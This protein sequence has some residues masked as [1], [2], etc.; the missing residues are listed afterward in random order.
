MAAIETERMALV[1]GEW[2]PGSAGS[3]EIRSPWDGSVVGAATAC[4][5]D[6][7]ALAV[8]AAEK[9]QREWA[10][11]SLL[12]RVDLFY[13]AMELAE[14]R[15]EAIAGLITAEM[16]K[17]IRESR[18][19][20]DEFGVPHFRRAAE[21]ALRYRGL[22]FPSTQERSNAKKMVMNRRPLG[23]VGVISPYNFPVDIALITIT[24]SLI[25]GNAV[26]WKPSELTPLSSGLAAEVFVEAGFPE[27]LVNF[28][29]GG[30]DVGEAIV[31]S[32]KVGAVSFTGSTP[33]GEAITRG[34]GLKRLLLELGGNGPIIVLADADLDR[35]VE[36]TIVGCFYM[37]GQCCTAAE[38]ILVDASVEE[39]YVAKLVARTER[40]KVGD[41]AD[42][43]TDMGPLVNRALLD[44][45]ERHVEDARAAGATV[46][47]I[48][49]LEG[50]TYPPTILTG[51]RPEMTI[52]REETFGPV[53][54][55]ISFDDPDEALRIANDSPYAL[56]GAVFTN[57]LREAWR[58][59][60]ELHH[61]TVL[62]NETTNY[63]DQLAPFGGAKSSG[64]GRELSTWM[65]D[66]VTEP[67]LIVF[68]VA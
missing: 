61:G 38:R 64:V 42:E 57:D 47:Q 2:R 56:N 31:A 8:E 51:V 36:A 63:W 14:D 16:G 5:A 6:D 37:A 68:D 67:K 54:P 30:A 29:P 62:V 25:A 23:I 40:M 24:Y 35:A 58:F 33:V 12:D 52:A 60:E 66:A 41:P 11:V 27:G 44:K 45:V 34:A 65:L 18:E 59:G 4:G 50:L 7:V 32:P 43:E 26:I 1:G 21:D 19:E 49:E 17:T 3:I 39:E 53:V 22:T 15:S 28:L 20:L 55:I 13:R 46:R 10:K 9:A 48:G